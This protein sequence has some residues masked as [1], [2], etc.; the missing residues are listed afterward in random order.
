MLLQLYLIYWW[1]S[2][3]TS[4]PAV[5]TTCDRNAFTSL[6]GYRIE[7][8]SS[9]TVCIK[10]SKLTIWKCNLIIDHSPFLRPRAF[11]GVDSLLGQTDT[12]R[13]R[14]ACMQ[15]DG[16]SWLLQ[17]CV[18]YAVH[19]CCAH[20]HR[21]KGCTN[22]LSGGFWV[23]HIARSSMATLSHYHS[24]QQPFSQSWPRESPHVCVHYRSHPACSLCT[25][26]H[27]D[28]CVHMW[29]HYQ[30]DLQPSLTC[31]LWGKLL[32]EVSRFSLVT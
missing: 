10:R 30:W 1:S 28:A 22:R 26:I 20:I 12:K 18:V 15:R 24:T 13:A 9:L 25:I 27:F 5:H 31:T 14:T 6:F 4:C 11:I 8:N 17:C 19:A 32:C 23:V 3:S 29:V 2:T 21:P 16:Q 7:H